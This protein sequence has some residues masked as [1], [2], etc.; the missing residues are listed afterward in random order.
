MHVAKGVT[1]VFREMPRLVAVE[2][3]VFGEGTLPRLLVLT[4]SCPDRIG[5]VAG[6]TRFLAEHGGWIVEANYHADQKDGWFFMRQAILADSFRLSV[7]DF[8]ARFSSIAEQFGISWKLSDTQYKKRLVLCVSRQDH[9]L[10]DLFHRWKTPEAGF[11]IVAV[12]SNHEDLR[13]FV[14][15]HE[16]PFRHVPVAPGNDDPAF[17][18]MARLYE[19]YRGESMVLARYMRILPPWFCQR[20]EGQ[21]LNIHH[22]FLPSFVGARPYH[23]AYDR[24]VKLIGATCHYVTGDL[25][26]GP[27]IEQDVIRVDHGD[28]PEEMARLGRDIERIVLARGVQYHVEDR[29]L[30]HGS[31]TIVFR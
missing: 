18:E 12:F 20:F 9:C 4:M 2:S 6:V 25:D 17:E 29:V 26:A 8:G 5:I 15:W 21:I 19:C 28:S 24:G 10:S 14:E 11:D 1:R 22:S 7:P 27:I 30:I 16:V 3:C 31:K 23:Q 13:P